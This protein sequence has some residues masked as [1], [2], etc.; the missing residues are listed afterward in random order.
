[1]TVVIEDEDGKITIIT[2]G[3]ESI[4]LPLCSHGPMDIT[5]KHIGDFA[6]VKIFKI[7]ILIKLQT[8]KTNSLDC[9]L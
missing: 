4:V 3:A 8:N 9:E 7:E 2:K 6:C 1:M 5:L